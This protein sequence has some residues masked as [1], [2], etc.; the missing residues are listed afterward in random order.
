MSKQEERNPP[1]GGRVSAAPA[2]NLT[3]AR[4]PWVAR[5]GLCKTWGTT[6][7]PALVR[8]LPQTQAILMRAVFYTQAVN[9]WSLRAVIMQV[10]QI[11]AGREGQEVERETRCLLRSSY[12]PFPESVHTNWQA[13]TSRA[14]RK[15][16]EVE[17]PTR[18]VR[19]AHS[20]AEHINMEKSLVC[21]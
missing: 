1:P 12:A 3:A 20:V 7:P 17:S 10:V 21:N 5:P 19:F 18:C 6:A 13:F 9:L 8:A 16:Q 4:I 15:G 2:Q 11:R 14:G